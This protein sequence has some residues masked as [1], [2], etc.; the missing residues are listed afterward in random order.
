MPKPSES[1]DFEGI[2][3]TLRRPLTL[4]K[5]RYS[6][7]SMMLSRREHQ[8]LI[9]YLEAAQ[10][11]LETSNQRR[12]EKLSRQRKAREQERRNRRNL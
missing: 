5:G 4:L 9:E 3:Y 1:F 12:T 11:I 10:A 7:A 8:Q 2:A 6:P